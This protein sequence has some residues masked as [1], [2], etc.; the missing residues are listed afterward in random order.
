MGKIVLAV[1]E[2]TRAVGLLWQ[3]APVAGLSDW[4]LSV[5][6]QGA[7]NATNAQ[8]TIRP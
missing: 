7:Y 1:S 4:R 8:L 5:R 2:R 6:R 3:L